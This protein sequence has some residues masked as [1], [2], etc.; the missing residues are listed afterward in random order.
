M[1]ERRF[2]SFDEYAI[3]YR[4]I[5][6]KNIE[7]SGADSFYFAEMK[8]KILTEFETNKKLR[9]LDLGCGDGATEI[10]LKKYFPHWIATGIDVS[11]KSI[12]EAKSK[13]AD[14]EYEVYNGIDIPYSNNDF[15]IVFVAGVFHHV[16]FSL[17]EKLMIEINRVLKQNGRF[18]LFEHNPLNP[19]TKY[20]VR[21]CIFDK[22]AKL[23]QYSYTQKLLQNN[24]FVVS[25]KRFIIFFP[26]KGLLSR[27]IFL[28]KYFKWLP[29][30]GQYFF[31]SIKVI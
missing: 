8:V 28:E 2:D 1:S 21:T 23:L 6:N 26:R 7:L 9:I 5:H 11:G 13:S 20:L 22:N 16:D 31:R 3:G 27:L 4:D 15:D 17:H 30:G 24:G 12:A 19:L 25:L 29:L 10:Y 18:Y 14:V